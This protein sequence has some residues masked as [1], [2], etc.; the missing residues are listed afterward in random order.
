MIKL[1]AVRG[2]V[3]V[4]TCV[5]LVSSGCA[6]HG[7]NSLPLPGAVGRGPGAEIYHIEIANVGSLQSNSPV[8]MN[9]VVVGSI[10]EMRVS[11]NW[12]AD[13][14]VSLQPGV[15]VPA[16]AVA[17]AG[18]TSLLGS[19]HLALGPPLGEAPRGVLP[20]GSVIPLSKTRTFPSTEQT[21]SAVSV[22]INDGGLG[23]IGDII[24][25]FGAALSGHETQV[26]DLLARLDEFIG[27]INEQ[28][29][30]VIA[31]IDSL[32]R[33]A[34]TVASQHGLVSTA[35]QKIPPALDVLL[36][37]RSRF[38]AALDKLRNFSDTTTGLINDSQADLVQ[39]LQ[40]LEPTLRALA[41]VGSD[42]D[43]SLAYL[44][45][46]PFTQNILDR[47]LRGDYLNLYVNVDLTIPRLKRT[48]WGTRYG[49][50]HAKIVPA[51]GDPY[52]QNFSYPA[53]G[54][55][56]TPPNDPPPAGL[57]QPLG[58][59]PPMMTDQTL[60]P[61]KPPPLTP[62]VAVGDS[63]PIFAGPYSNQAAAAPITGTP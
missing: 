13:V 35:L 21:L 18:Q 26:R 47:S 61:V 32:N 37:E 48:L 7:L 28:R 41:D 36:R 30:R 31:T 42:L 54:V 43:T 23:Q 60:L 39:N 4:S 44:P 9:D 49:D 59:L 51:P 63:A 1:T 5:V 62:P 38:T 14:A 25:N 58:A 52:Y 11:K 55:A 46:F 22:L 6:F 27:V 24:H 12:R 34:G 8:L 16:N 2:A 10:A 20:A 3:A 53:S 57:P 15:V 19:M 56:E 17:S 45:T 50:A 40:H 29:S 33:L